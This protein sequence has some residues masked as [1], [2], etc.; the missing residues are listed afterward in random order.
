MI[1]PNNYTIFGIHSNAERYSWA[2]YHL[3][4]LLSSIIGD[5]LILYATFQK[6]AFRLN[7]FIVSIMQCIA[8]CDLVSVITVVF[9][10]AVSLLT[11]TWV[12]GD[13][14]CYAR[15]YLGRYSYFVGMCL[16]AAMTTG[17]FLLVK[18]PLRSTYLT[19]KMAY[20]ISIII[21]MAY[22]A[23]P[24]NTLIVDKDDIVFDYRVYGCTHIFTKGI[25]KT[26]L[27]ITVTITMFI[28]NIV[29]VATT[30][31]ILVMARRS[32]RRFGESVQWRGALPVVLTAVVY[33]TSTI[34]FFV[35]YI[36]SKF[37]QDATSTFHVEYYRISFFMVMIN[38]MSN[39]Y[40]YTLTI[41]SF[42]RFLL[43]KIPLN[44][45]SSSH[46]S[47]NMKSSAG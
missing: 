25:W 41:R 1:P 19:K 45:S 18:Y 35:Y 27:P 40:I 2:A 24:L 4:V 34:P 12:L 36:G 9:P 47:G 3:F 5:T 43:T 37:I 38:I 16:I 28:P 15:E 7:R 46:V 30:I 39:F 44:R 11:N 29:I 6:D 23:L 13:A 42:R 22:L 21:F 10:G 8:V 26:L 17:K 14:M 33:C 31:P 32:A 20:K